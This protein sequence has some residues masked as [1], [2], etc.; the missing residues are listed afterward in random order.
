LATFS[1]GKNVHLFLKKMIWAKFWAIVSQ[2]HLA[3]L[4]PTLLLGSNYPHLV[5]RQGLLKID[6]QVLLFKKSAEMPP[7]IFLSK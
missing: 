1:S 7:N 5:D 3:T 4:P 6:D 2:T